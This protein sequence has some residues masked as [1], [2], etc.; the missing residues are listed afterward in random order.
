MWW[1]L[2]GPV[3]YRAMLVKTVILIEEAWVYDTRSSEE[4]PANRG[5]R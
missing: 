2:S 3:F 5:V 4:D 1:L